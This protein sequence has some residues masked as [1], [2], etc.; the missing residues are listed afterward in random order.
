[1]RGSTRI[2]AL[3]GGCRLTVGEVPPTVCVPQTE[4]LYHE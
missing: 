4:R 3:V 2:V 1:M